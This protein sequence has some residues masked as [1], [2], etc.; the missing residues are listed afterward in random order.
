MTGPE[1]L[2][3]GSVGEAVRD[4]QQRLAQ[5][6][7]PTDDEV[8]RFGPSTQAAV[9]GF[10]EA[11]GIHVD[12]IC[13]RETWAALVESGFRPGDRLLF[14]RSPNLRGDDIVELQHR[15]NTLGFDAGRED[16]IFGP[17]TTAA[18]KE[19]QR[20][21]GISVDGIAGPATATAMDRLGS[22]AEGSVAAVR[23][24]EELRDP[25]R[26]AGHRI[27]L[28]VA[29]GLEALGEA[30]DRA[31][32]AARAQTLRDSTGEDDSTVAARANQYQADLFLAVRPGDRPGS[33]SLYFASGQFR[34]EA[35]FRIARAIQQQLA[36]LLP[37]AD[38]PATCGRA[39][40][41][42]RETRMAAIVCELV[43]EADPDAM[44]PLVGSVPSVAHALVTGIQLGIEGPPDD[45][46]SAP[47]VTS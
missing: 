38:D 47:P 1:V 25:R 30:I 43:H 6:D 11:R 35:G 44:A 34:S 28:R 36:V 40:T 14:L 37:P 32:T 22:L 7:H 23:E 46:R 29:P 45:D 24:R 16:G 12:S 3:L 27:Y 20:N 21:A 17:A 26:L 15:L 18:L 8:G 10:Q 13:G 2:R 42:L 4:L 39:Y 41:A 9:R 31:L 19:F 5:A 33:R